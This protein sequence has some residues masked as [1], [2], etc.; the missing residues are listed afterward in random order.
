ML[1]LGIESSCD[2]TAVALI[3]SADGDAE[4]ELL[5]SLISSQIPL[6]RLY[7]G[8]VPE[9]ASRNHSACLPGLLRKALDTA[10]ADIREVDVFAATAG[11]GLAAAL[12]VGHTAGK[13]LALAAGKPFVAVNHLE[14]H[15]LS[16]FV[17]RPGALRPH[18]GLLVSGGHSLLVDVHGAGNYRLLGRSLDDAAGEA[19]DKIGKMLDLP[20]PGGPEIDRLGDNGDPS[21]FA[22]PRPLLHSQTL[23]FSF[24]G[25]KTAVLY[26][27]QKLAPGG[28][29]RLLSAET[30]SDL[31]A[32]VRQAIVETLV[33]KAFAALR[34]TRRRT[35]AASGGVSCNAELRR[36]LAER[37]RAEQI[38]L[39]L[40]PAELTTD[41]AAMI[42]FAA[43]L[44]ARAGLFSSLEQPVDP[45]LPLAGVQNRA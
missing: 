22:L 38:E 41:N 18:L 15:L 6:H 21:A 4:P 26:L 13:A 40:P 1:T 9:L 32:S 28:D 34:L 25:L 5:C 39:I 10:G 27:L 8:V 24:S 30:R 19:F 42:A 14:G 45:N 2:E 17:R 44:K 7:G 33:E 36:R 16:P 29:P 43:M 11:P 12:L 23:D 3:R 35:L 20:Y 31:C 37:C